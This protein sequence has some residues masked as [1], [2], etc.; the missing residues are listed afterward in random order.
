[1][2][3]L[4][5][6]GAG[7]IGSNTVVELQ[8]RG[9]RVAI[10][11]N[12]SNSHPEV[13]NRIE[14]ITGKRPLFYE[15]DIRNET[16]LDKVFKNNDFGAVIHFA[17]L[18]AVG[19]SVNEPLKY[20]RNNIDA[21]ISLLGV[22]SKYDVRKLIF[23]SSATVYGSARFPYK[24]NYMTGVGIS[25]P[26]GQTK[27]MIEQIL[28]DTAAA[29]PKN[30]FIALRY[31]N[32]I[33][34][35]KSG[36]LG[37]D[38]SGIPNNL[39]PFIE[40]VASGRRTELLI[41]GNDYDTPDGTCKRDY[42]HVTDLSRGHVAALDNLKKGFDYINLGSGSSTSVLELIHI[43]EKSTGKKIAY[44]F[45]PRRAGDLAEFFADTTKA[46]K[47]MGWQTKLTLA[48]ACRDSWNWQSKN[49]SGYPA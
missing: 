1:M 8:N 27:Y 33:G 35:H 13:L 16:K 28:R 7:Y 45:A 40:Q 23:S 32:P 10:V 4:V 17:G 18:K 12:F 31:F 29:D 6:G 34:A 25:N 22:M 36:L 43:F 15:L 46:S 38:P 20:Y 26:Y 2:N 11:D 3:I 24:E 9:D 41:F 5:T 48:D 49:P 39:M 19:E 42:I 47:V 14:Q 21:T 37:E 30:E 44:K